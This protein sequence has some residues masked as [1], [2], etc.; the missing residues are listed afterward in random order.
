LIRGADHGEIVLLAEEI[1]VIGID[2]L[3]TR[4]VSYLVH[5]SRILPD[6]FLLK[7][8]NSD[9]LLH[10]ICA[11]GLTLEGAYLLV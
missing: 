5:K 11:D 7:D 4:L 9:A 10:H 6:Y 2:L 8:I 3:E 1:H